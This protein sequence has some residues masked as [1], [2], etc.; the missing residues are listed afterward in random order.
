MRRG[1]P[2]PKTG[3]HT[4][5]H[6]RH[7]TRPPCKQ[8]GDTN[9]RREGHHRSTRPS[10][11]MPPHHTMPPHHPRWPHPPPRRG[12]ST[13]RIPHHTKKY[14]QRHTHTHHST[15]QLTVAWHDSSTDE[16]CTGMGETWAGQHTLSRP[17]AAHTT[18]IP[19]TTHKRM[20]TIHS[21]S[22]TVHVHSTNERS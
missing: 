16:Y 6:S 10:I 17:A 8:K 1:G 11:S 21:S 15:R 2:N 4:H 20:D 12:G 9:N 22:H 18:A 19:Y 13:Q 3:H 14:G 7:S 5:H